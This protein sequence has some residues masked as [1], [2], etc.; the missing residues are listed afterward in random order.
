LEV[1]TNNLANSST[2]GFKEHRVLFSDYLSR[3]HG[4]DLVNG[5]KVL[6]YSQD[7]STYLDTLQGELRQTGNPLD[8]AING[9]GYF[10]VRTPQGLRLTRNGQLHRGEDGTI[11]DSSGDPVLDDQ[12]RP[13]TLN[14]DEQILPLGIGADGTISTEKGI[15]AKLGLATVENPNTL[16][17]EG[18]HL[19]RPTTELQNVPTQEIRQGML[20]SSNVNAVEETTAMIKTQREYDLNFQLLQ[21]EF[22]R[23]LNAID[24]IPAEPTT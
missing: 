1:T 13:I 18:N 22:T 20:E 15:I 23:R 6:T 24:K 5:E 11:V 9:S 3:Q 12:R 21:T 19:F 2:D 17:A 10:V 8:L 7:R 4:A 16:H 14:A